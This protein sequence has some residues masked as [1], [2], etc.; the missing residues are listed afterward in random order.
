MRVGT[1]TLSRIL[2]RLGFRSLRRRQL[3]GRR[4]A[5]ESL[6]PRQMLTATPITVT[7]LS[8]T[9]TPN[10]GVLSL[11]EALYQADNHPAMT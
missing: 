9:S 8:S 11:F 3:A 1:G 4:L 10:D 7:T 5:V 2:T 6:E